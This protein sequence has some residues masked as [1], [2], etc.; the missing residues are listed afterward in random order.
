MVEKSQSH[1]D[2]VYSV[3]KW[4]TV[5]MTQSQSLGEMEAKCHTVGTTSPNTNGGTRVPRSCGVL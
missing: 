5:F 2:K 3:Y 4:L 1:T